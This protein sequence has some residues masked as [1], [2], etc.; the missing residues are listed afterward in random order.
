MTMEAWE[1][2]RNELQSGSP[3]GILPIS[4]IVGMRPRYGENA[5]ELSIEWPSWNDAH[6][7]KDTRFPDPGHVPHSGTMW[8]YATPTLHCSILARTRTAESS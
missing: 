5:L 4:A 8:L 2:L 3:I 6:V 7:R 1:R